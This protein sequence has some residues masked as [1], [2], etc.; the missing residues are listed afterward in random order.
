[1]SFSKNSCEK[2]LD[3]SYFSFFSFQLP[4]FKTCVNPRQ[5]LSGVES[6]TK[7]VFG[8]ANHTQY[9]Y[10]QTD[11]SN[12]LKF[13]DHNHTLTSLAEMDQ[14]FLLFLSVQCLCSEADALPH[15]IKKQRESRPLY[16]SLAML[17]EIMKTLWVT[18]QEESCC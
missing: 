13:S 15:Y 7:D 3:L 17:A 6:T 10:S 11:A 9:S 8:H 16:Q 5:S 2:L 14:H 18:I 12:F 1:M 4:Y